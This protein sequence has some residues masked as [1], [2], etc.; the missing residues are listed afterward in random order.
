[1]LTCERGLGKSIG[2][3]VTSLGPEL[4][5]TRGLG[6]VESSSSVRAGSD[7]AAADSEPAPSKPDVALSE[8][9]GSTF[10]DVDVLP[11]VASLGGVGAL[12]EA[13]F[14]AS[15]GAP[16]EGAVPQ[17]TNNGRIA[18]VRALVAIAPG[19]TK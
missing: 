2:S 10:G 17:A 15:L 19:L 14:V 5:S 7:P 4:T 9:V 3:L 18:D 6:P 8:P 12:A 1:M 11:L 13:E 16:V